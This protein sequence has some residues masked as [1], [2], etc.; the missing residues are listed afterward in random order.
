MT[1]LPVL[2]APRSGAV[3]ATILFALMAGFTVSVR[4]SDRPL[5][6]HKPFRLLL[7]GDSISLGYFPFVQE[8][9]TGEAVVVSSGQCQGTRFVREHFDQILATG[10]GDWDV[11]HFNA[12]LHDVKENRIVPIKEYETNLRDIIRRLKATKARIVWAS[13]TPLAATPQNKDVT[14]YNATA[15][16]VMEASGIPIDDLYTHM[17]PRLTGNQKPDGMHFEAAGSKLL[18]GFVANSIRAV[19]TG[20]PVETGDAWRAEHPPVTNSLGMKMM[21]IPAG[22]FLMGDNPGTYKGEDQPV[23]SI[24]WNDAVAIKRTNI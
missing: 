6:Q 5:I 19:M 8:A 22:R 18:A 7:I 16:R 24:C 4:A 13:T 20:T 17:R 23:E 12:G 2:N 1:R 10:G 3:C 15:K 14:D 11:I 9:L 21:P